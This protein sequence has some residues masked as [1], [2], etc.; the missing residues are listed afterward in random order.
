MHRAAVMV[1]MI[2]GGVAP[3]ALAATSLVVPAGGGLGALA[4]SVDVPSRAVRFAACKAEPCATSD[5][6]ASVPIPG[7]DTP[8]DA[9]RVHVEDV[10]LAGGRHLAHVTVEL[11][12]A[13]PEALAWEAL[14]ALAPSGPTALFSGF[15][16]WSRGEP[17]E[18]AGTDVRFLSDDGRAIVVI[19]DIREDLRICGDDATLLNPRGLD[20]TTL[21]FRGATLQRLPQARRDGAVPVTATPRRAHPDAALAPLLHATEASS[22]IGPAA[23]LTDGDLATAWSEGRPGRGQGEFVV[24]QAPFDVPI[25][26]FSATLSP[27]TPRPK[28]GSDGASPETFY[29]ATGAGTFE[30]T[31]PEDA[32]SHPGEAYD[33]VLPAPIQTSCVALVLADAFTRGRPHP[34]VTVAELTAYSAFDH[35][36][37]TLAQVASSMA[38]GDAKASAAAALLERA[39]APGIEAMMTAYAKLDPAG[40]ALAMNVAASAPSCASSGPMLTSALADADELVRGKAKAKLEEPTCGKEA[41][42]ALIEGLKGDATRARV[43]S[44]VALVGRERA[45]G[46]L[47]A[48]LGQG[49]LEDR[50]AVR[51]AT[52][53]AARGAA[54]EEVAS[55]LSAA[56]RRSADGTIEA[57]R[58]FRDRLGD[59][60]A[61]AD[62]VV[63]T[64]LGSSPPM[65]TRY[66]MVDV[67]AT[68]ASA[69]P[70]DA[71]AREALTSLAT[72]DAAAE[73][74]A[75]AAEALASTAQPDAVAAHA[76]LDDAPR[77]REAALRASGA[78]H[79]SSVGPQAATLLAKDPWTFVRVAA[80]DALAALPA[81]PPSDRALTDALDQLAPRVRVEALLALGAHGPAVPSA[82]RDAVRH[83][84][85]GPKEDPPVRAA[86]ARALGMLCDA[87]AVDDLTHLA[88]AGGSSQDAAEVA[89]GLVATEALGMLH[90]KDLAGR[91]AALSSKGVRPD[92][93]AAAA[94][95]VEGAGRCAGEATGR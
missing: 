70:G 89:L 36:G 82:S 11:A 42:P 94:K 66:L 5:A 40:R 46:P 88:V 77:V 47:A 64:L 54:P 30:V 6:S 75:H 74:R 32:W 53:L 29:L 18:R 37:A 95:A 34:V 86:A 71:V 50:A 83:R 60:H 38:G 22:S 81:T 21:L 26:R 45:L 2:L 61:A 3:P 44:L 72:T 92:A 33:I 10:L 55:L 39:G 62:P 59:I 14:L 16:G 57:L 4:V 20:P 15:T 35:P 43:A 9:S 68:L 56:Y 76:L 58:A 17:G 49:S 24:M 31:V 90:P 67:L 91:F 69:G 12:P 63:R 19:G 80:A 84:L 87:K 78:A 28:P 73:V 27:L 93:R 7:G 23:A 1:G 25:V 48:E 41:L 79:L 51:A 85:L 65:P 13:G 52:A 8:L